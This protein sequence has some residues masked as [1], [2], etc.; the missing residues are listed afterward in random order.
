MLTGGGSKSN[1][2]LHAKMPPT[3]QIPM[4]SQQALS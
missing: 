4:K 2:D 3:P 1:N